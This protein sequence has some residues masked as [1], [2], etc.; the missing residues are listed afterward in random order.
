M[1]SDG[2]AWW[3]LLAALVAV[4]VLWNLYLKEK[5]KATE[6]RGKTQRAKAFYEAFEEEKSGF[7]VYIANE[8]RKVCYISPNFEKMTGLE[9]ELLAA[10]LDVLKELVSPQ[11]RR[12]LQKE[13]DAWDKKGLLT[14]E[15]PYHRLHS[16]TK[17]Y[18]RIRITETQEGHLLSCVDMTEDFKAREQM[19]KELAVAKKESSAKTDFLSQM[20]HEIRTPMNGIMGMLSLAKVHIDDRQSLEEYLEKTESL[21]QFLLTLIN[22]ILDMSRIESGKMELEKVPFDLFALAE[23]LDNM[24]RNTAESKGIHW[25]VELQDF[26]EHYVVGD[27]MRLSQV[28]INFIS[29]ANKFTPAGGNV[30]VTFRQMDKIDDK[31][32]LMIRVRDTGKGIRRD[33]LDKI[34][35]PF[36]QEDASTAHNYGGSGLG[37]AIAD[38]IVKLMGG[39]ILVESEEGKGSEFVVYVALPLAA[40]DQIAEQESQAQEAAE[41][42]AVPED[43]T[44]DGI[45]ILLAEDNDIN[46]EIAMEILEM[47]GAIVQRACD[48][49]EVVQMFK[50]SELHAYDVIL[51]DIQMPKMDGWEATEVIRKLEREDADILIFAMS[52]NAFLEDRR[53]SISV[54]MNGHINKPV[55]F[56][57]LRQMIGEQLYQK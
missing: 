22:D 32:H 44:L 42:V 6:V 9:E 3:L 26:D 10:D 53:H 11:M 49:E 56:D 15:T 41:K 25:S 29:N 21:S 34:F 43:F 28:I 17:K 4:A 7:Y 39:E 19:K 54:G 16:E 1:V 33:F 47:N 57:E 48:G 45:H 12:K 37:M 38:N 27:E 31:L 20:S 36:E 18:A 51:M 50:D 13:I 23:N 52:A 24:F 40:Q 35:R 14:L 55:D 46:A 8:G 5:K 2:I 30:T